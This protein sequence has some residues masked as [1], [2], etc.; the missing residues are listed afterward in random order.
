MVWKK[1]TGDTRET[2]AAYICKYFISEGANIVVYD[3]QVEDEEMWK[4]L[5]YVGCDLI[6]Q[7]HITRAKTAVEAGGASCSNDG[8][9]YVQDLDFETIRT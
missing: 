6:L 7:K 1:D 8:V 2:A 4:E 3:P 9:G 5:K